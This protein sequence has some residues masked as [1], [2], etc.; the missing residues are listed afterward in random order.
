MKFLPCP[1]CGSSKAK[2]EADGDGN[3]W[4]VCGGCG[5]HGPLENQRQTEDDLTWN[6]R[7]EIESVAKFIEAI[8]DGPLTTKATKSYIAARVR[9]LKS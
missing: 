5:A 3:G 7:A 2:F 4:A 9:E 8:D 6:S 1:F